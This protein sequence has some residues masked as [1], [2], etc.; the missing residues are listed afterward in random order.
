MTQKAFDKMGLLVL[1]KYDV[2]VVYQNTANLTK[3]REAFVLFATAKC[4]L[5]TF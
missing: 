1:N 2:Q 3:W 4:S 5:M